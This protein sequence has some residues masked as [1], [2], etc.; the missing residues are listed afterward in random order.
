MLKTIAIFCI[1]TIMGCRE[2]E[3]HHL[4]GVKTQLPV[5]AKNVKSIS[6]GIHVQKWYTFELEIEGMLKRFL[7][8]EPGSRQQA[9]SEISP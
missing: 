4:A 1:F 2:T 8:V 9:I 6:S 5:G 7:I 3:E